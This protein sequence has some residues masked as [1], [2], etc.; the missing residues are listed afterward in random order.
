MNSIV[1]HLR[2]RCILE[3]ALARLDPPSAHTDPESR[4]RT[5]LALGDS[6]SIYSPRSST[7]VTVQGRAAAPGQAQKIVAAMVD[8]YLEEHMRISRSP[9]SYQFFT[10]QSRRLD[11]QL[12]AAQGALRDAKNTAGIASIEG[13]RTAIEGQINAVETQIHQVAAALAAAEARLST[14]AALVRALPEPLLKQ[15]VGGIPND[16]LAAMR[17]QLFQLQVHEEEV[18]SKYTG[19]HPVAAAVHQ[20]VQEVSG[21]LN[22]E[23][24]DR[25]H[26]VVA[27]CAQDAANRASLA[28]QKDILQDQLGRLQ[29]SLAKLNDDEVRIAKLSRSAQQIET[30]YLAYAGNKEQARMDQAL[31]LERISNLSVIQP[32][33]LAILPVSPRKGITLFLAAVGGLLGGVLIALVSQQWRPDPTRG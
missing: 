12:E 6:L 31:R 14:L 1:E 13:R 30:Q 20:Q 16:G 28:A 3:R 21:E 5:L 15:M 10:E 11:E 32:A 9:A 24:P 7:V 29:R 19:S 33:T 27:I 17:G 4:E 22:R 2:S 25:A 18:R 23:E 8:V 26:L